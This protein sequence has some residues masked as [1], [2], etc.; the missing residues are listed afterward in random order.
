MA[1]ECFKDHQNSKCHKGAATLWQLSFHIVVI[2]KT[3]RLKTWL[4]ST[5][6][7]QR[8]NSLAI[9]CE[10]SNEFTSKNDKRYNQFGQFTEADFI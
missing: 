1:P 5:M 7:S 10:I 6:A 2:L 4:R 3:R 9:L 8:F